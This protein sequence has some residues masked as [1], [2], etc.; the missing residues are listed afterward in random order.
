MLV[1]NKLIVPN[2]QVVRS[3]NNVDVLCWGWNYD[4]QFGIGDNTGSKQKIGDA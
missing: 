3:K 2:L 1:L 4:G